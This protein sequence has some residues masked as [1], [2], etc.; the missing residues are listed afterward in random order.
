[1]YVRCYART[2]REARTPKE[3]DEIRSPR[4]RPVRSNNAIKLY[5]RRSIEMS[6]EFTPTRRV[7]LNAILR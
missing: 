2:T 6:N 1:M 7:S 5:V 4:R 3:H